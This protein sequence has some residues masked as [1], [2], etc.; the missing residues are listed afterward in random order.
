MN[1][2]TQLTKK[3]FEA[4]HNAPLEPAQWSLTDALGHVMNFVARHDSIHEMPGLAEAIQAIT[5]R[6][7]ENW[8]TRY[9]EYQES[10]IDPI[11]REITE[12]PPT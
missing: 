1:K 12:Q 6:D 11:E 8:R 5:P 9:P 2:F 7:W 10:I 4:Y 3:A